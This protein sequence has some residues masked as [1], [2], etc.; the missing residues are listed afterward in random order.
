MKILYNMEKNNCVVKYYN[1]KYDKIHLSLDTTLCGLVKEILMPEYYLLTVAS[2]TISKPEIHIGVSDHVD[3]SNDNLNTANSI[4]INIFGLVAKPSQ[5]MNQLN[6]I[7]NDIQYSIYFVNIKN[8]KKT[9]ATRPV[10]YIPDNNKMII[11]CIV[12]NKDD[13]FKYIDEMNMG[14]LSTKKYIGIAAIE[15]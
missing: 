8:C 10:E 5:F 11:V 6:V 9:Y 2:G 14:N 15:F 13:I 7:I 12:G 4:I 3:I 1:N